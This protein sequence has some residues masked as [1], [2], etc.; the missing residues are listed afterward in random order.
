M[1]LNNMVFIGKPTTPPTERS[2][3]L[4]AGLYRLWCKI[5]RPQVLEWETGSACFWDRAVAG[6]C[7]LRTAILREF[8]HE[9]VGEL[10]LCSGGVY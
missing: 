2:I 5:R 4:T 8:R 7:A 1:L 10:G 3:T 9:V 6:S